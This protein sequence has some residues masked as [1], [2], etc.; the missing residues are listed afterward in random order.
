MGLELIEL[1]QQPNKPEIQLSQHAVGI[2][3]L[4]K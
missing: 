1:K 3:A 4:S 2:L